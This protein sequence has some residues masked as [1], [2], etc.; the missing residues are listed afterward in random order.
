MPTP[1]RE[2]NSSIDITA[3][4]V[5]E[6]DKSSS[7]E[8]NSESDYDSDDSSASTNRDTY[9]C[10]S[11]KKVSYLFGVYIIAVLSFQSWFLHSATE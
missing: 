8:D 1:P 7:E 5:S 9:E 3:I 6:N 11:Q 10:A 2:T 4:T